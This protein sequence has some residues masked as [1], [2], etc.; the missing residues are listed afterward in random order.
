MVYVKVRADFFTVDMSSFLKAAKPE[1]PTLAGIKY[2]G[3]DVAG[4]LKC[5]ID[6]GHEF[7]ILWGRDDVSARFLAD[8]LPNILLGKQ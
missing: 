3:F 4:A 2:S 8:E 7:N 6:Y 1:M 5:H